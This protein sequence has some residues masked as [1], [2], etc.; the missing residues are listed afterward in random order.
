MYRKLVKS[1]PDL[2]DTNILKILILEVTVRGIYYL[3]IC[4]PV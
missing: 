4:L 1:F 2:K 3:L